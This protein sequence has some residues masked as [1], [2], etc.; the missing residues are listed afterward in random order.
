M[1]N[2]QKE[3]LNNISQFT[4]FFKSSFLSTFFIDFAKLNFNEEDFKRIDNVLENYSRQEIDWQLEDDL[5]DNNQLLF[6]YAV[7]KAENS[8]LTLKEAEDIF[9]AIKSGSLGD[10]FLFLEKKLKNKEKINQ[11]DHD[12]LEYK[13]IAAGFRHFS[14]RGIKV[15]DLSLGLILDIH[16]KLTLG[17]DVFADYLNNFE[18]Y[19][20]GEWRNDNNTK[21]G[22]YAPADYLQIKENVK[23]LII[24]LKKNPSVINIFIFHIALYAIHPFKNGNKR[25]CRLLEHY[26]LQDLG[27]NTKDLFSLSYYYHKQKDRYYKYLIESLIKHDFTYFTSLAGEAFYFSVCG[28]IARVLSRK[29]DEVIKGADLEKDTISIIRPLIKRSQANFTKLL[30]LNKRKVSRQ[31]LSNHLSLAVAKGILVRKKIGRNVFYSI[32]PNN[33]EEEKILKDSLKIA[34]EKN[35]FIP[36][37]LVTYL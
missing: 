5:Q 29:K 9:E 4:R 28:I 14:D 11:S 23:E 12:K 7:S 30:A 37:N 2:N 15:K 6:S 3:K 19:R 13:N 16:Q 22:K 18:T 32:S 21:V 27:Y 34:Q 20:S 25:V 1:Q 10:D 35:T 8:K 24:W 36:D 33:Y 26:L 17:L 31:T